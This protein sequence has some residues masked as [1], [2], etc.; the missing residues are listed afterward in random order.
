MSISRRMVILIVSSATGNEH[1][2][3]EFY[4]MNIILIDYV[5]HF[6]SVVLSGKLMSVV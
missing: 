5:M 2:I 4:M 1:R 3:I 6:S